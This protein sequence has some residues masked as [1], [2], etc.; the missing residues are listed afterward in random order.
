M[1][2]PRWV[3]WLFLAFLIYILA[4]G[5]FQAPREPAPATQV[6]EEAPREYKRLSALVDG[7]RW[8][9]ALKPDYV[10]SDA[11][12]AIPEHAD[13]KL[14]SYAIVTVNGEGAEAACGQTITTRVM[15]WSRDGTA[16]KPE[17]LTLKLGEQKG[18]DGLLV[19]MRVGEERLVHFTPA[20]QFRTLTYNGRAPQLI[21]V[22]RVEDAPAPEPKAAN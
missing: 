6:A 18:L 17:P 5:N 15:R 21:T 22:R 1:Y 10:P 11:A 4:V 3:S 2:F 8:L 14:P 20:A 13:D 19:G 7:E 16:G 12:C 9:S